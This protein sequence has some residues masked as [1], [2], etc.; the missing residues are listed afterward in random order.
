MTWPNEKKMNDE[1]RKSSHTCISTIHVIL[2]PILVASRYT[3]HEVWYFKIEQKRN[4]QP[5]RKVEM[6][7]TVNSTRKYMLLNSL[8]FSVIFISIYVNRI[9]NAYTVYCT[10]MEYTQMMLHD[11]QLFS[12]LGENPHKNEESQESVKRGMEAIYCELENKKGHS[13]ASKWKNKYVI[14]SIYSLHSVISAV[15]FL[16]LSTSYKRKITTEIENSLNLTR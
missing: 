3:L 10:F 1:L 14:Y 16:S 6:M 9:K 15:H 5:R 12:W 2:R 13:H 11:L 8:A 7:P 4:N